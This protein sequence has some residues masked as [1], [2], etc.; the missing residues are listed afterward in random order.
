MYHSDFVDKKQLETKQQQ[1]CC[2][3]NGDKTQSEA[4]NQILRTW[5]LLYQVAIMTFYRIIELNVAE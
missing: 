2:T 4:Q 5:E 3:K 1:S